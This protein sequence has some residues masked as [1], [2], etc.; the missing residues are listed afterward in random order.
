MEIKLFYLAQLHNGEHAA[1]HSE[2]LEHLTLSNPASLGVSEQSETYRDALNRQN[3]A[4]DVFTASESSVESEKLDRR[5]D[6]AYS[7]LKAYLKVCANDENVALNAVAE[8]LLF[9]IRESA[10]EVGN[11]IY[12]GLAK[13]TAAINSLLRNFEPLQADI[14]FT[15]AAGRLN[16]LKNANR[17]FEEL[18]IQRSIEKAWKHSGNVKAARTVTDAAYRS[19]VERINAQALL[20]G[21]SALDAFIKEQNVIIDK[22][23]GI[24]AQRKGVA[25]KAD[26]TE[27]PSPDSTN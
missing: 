16:E 22:Y 11:P 26:K 8:R 24:V 17:A 21:G 6:K 20:Y 3:Q 10:I 27:N 15:G 23:A 5:R 2:T 7:A 14:E 9:V 12:L 13:E 25:K 19:V 4:I 1:Y 18:Q